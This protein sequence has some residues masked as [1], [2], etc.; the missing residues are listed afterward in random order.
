MQQF[1]FLQ[2]VVQYVSSTFCKITVPF[3]NKNYSLTFY[4]LFAECILGGFAVAFDNFASGV[5][6]REQI[7]VCLLE[8]TGAS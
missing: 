7:A 5:T 1:I 4:S 8:N 2:W 3:H 6:I